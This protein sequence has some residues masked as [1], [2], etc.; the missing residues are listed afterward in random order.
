MTERVPYDLVLMDCQMPEMDGYEATQA[1]RRR[2]NGGRRL[3]IVAMTAH[4]MAGAREKCLDVGMDDYLSKPIRREA[5]QRVL[6]QWL[7]PEKAA[8]AS[9]EPPAQPAEESGLDPELTAN[10]QDLRTDGGEEFVAN[11]V[12]SFMR[13]TRERIGS[14]HRAVTSEDSAAVERLTHDLKGAAG[15]LGALRLAKLCRDLET[16][17]RSRSF[18]E[19]A[20]ILE[21]MDESL[22]QLES[23]LAPYGA[24]AASPQTSD[25]QPAS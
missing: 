4:A 19:A 23:S 11:L 2:E 16:S 15:T 7:R 6:E 20:A 24:H 9:P 1:I 5:L 8:A 14:M 25:L 12:V 13:N 22:E 21:R 18:G 10:L 3:P 17:V